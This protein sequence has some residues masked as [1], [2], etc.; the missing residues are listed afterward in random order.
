LILAAFFREARNKHLRR[1]NKKKKREVERVSEDLEVKS[2][3]DVL[4][5]C[6]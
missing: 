3:G 5:L 4:Q 6:N 1:I 2:S